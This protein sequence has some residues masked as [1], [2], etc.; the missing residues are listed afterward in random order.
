MYKINNDSVLRKSS[1]IHHVV[2]LVTVV[3]AAAVGSATAGKEWSTTIP[4]EQLADRVAAL[5]GQPPVRFNQYA[6][7]VTVNETHGRALFYWFFEA[8][9]NAHKRPLLLWLNGGI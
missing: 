8:T 9:D 5:P 3:L 6:G 2:V 4:A 1:R 7:Y